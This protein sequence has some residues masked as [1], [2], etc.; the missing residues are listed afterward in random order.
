MS[1]LAQ[2]TVLVV[3]DEADLRRIIAQ[4]LE[5][6]GFAV[7]Q[8]VDAADATSR[9]E[10]FA[11]DGLVVDLRLPDADGLDVLDAALARYP[12]I[13]AVVITGWG[14]VEEAVRAIKRGAIDFLIKPFQLV[15]L[16][17]VLH[18]GINERRLQLENAE[19]RAQ[20]HDRFAYS[21]VVGQSAAIQHVFSSL[22]LVSPMNST[23]LIHG[24]TG[25]GKELIARTIHYNSPRRDQHFVAFN[26]AAIPEG[27]AEAELFGHV[28]GAFTGAIAARVGRFELAHKGTLF[29]DEVSS[30]SLS[31]QA[32]LLRALQEREIER[33][34]ESRPFKFDIRL[35]AATNVDLRLAVKEGTFRE[36]LY[37]RLN[38]VPITLPPLRSRREDVALLAQHFVLKSCKHNGVAPRSISQAAMRLLMDCPWPGNIR[39]L[40]NAI[41]HAVAVS[42]AEREIG[43]AMLPEDLRHAGRSAMLAPVTIPD[44][45]LDFAAIMSE[46]E[47]ELI[48]RGLE[49]TGGNKR[50][51][52][53]LLNLSRTTLIDKLQR[54]RRGLDISAA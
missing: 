35:I 39:Q 52:A 32:K 10:G 21:S 23:V 46:L 37:Y 25:T 18:A 53:R 13:R 8:A 19:L 50:Q 51:A 33:V 20:L 11:Y 26:A 2:P 22:E 41:E 14:G 54:L 24:E 49:K 27:L 45:G 48:M 43:P 42:G 3:E 5:A 34:G 4:S 47:R 31:L 1:S 28:K 36:D 30:M 16:A 40:E 9:L 38:V 7:A 44:E 17:Q 29:I 6:K 12:E 15:Q